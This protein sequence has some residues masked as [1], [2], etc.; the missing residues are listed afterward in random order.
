MT[1]QQL[2]RRYEPSGSNVTEA[3]EP[4]A[5]YRHPDLK[6]PKVDQASTQLAGLL[7]SCA[8]RAMPR[9]PCC[10]TPGLPIEIDSDLAFHC[11]T[12]TTQ[13]TVAGTAPASSAKR[14]VNW[15]PF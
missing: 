10:S 13:A 12:R 7:A 11:S 9:R 6:T 14:R 5:R 15:I 8:H 4:H 3:V 2:F 1:V